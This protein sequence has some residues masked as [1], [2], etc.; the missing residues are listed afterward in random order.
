MKIDFCIDHSHPSLPGHFPGQPI[1]PGVVILDRIVA[2]IESTGV[3]IDTLR[4][5]QIKFLRPLLPGQFAQ[6]DL[7]DSNAPSRWRFKVY[8][9]AIAINEEAALIVSGEIAMMMPESANS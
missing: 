2:A 1:V 4:L 3:P 7:D 8:K 9:S 6:I 5:P